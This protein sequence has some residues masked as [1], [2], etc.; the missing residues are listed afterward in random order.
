MEQQRINLTNSKGEKV[1]ATLLSNISPVEL[2]NIENEWREDKRKIINQ[3]G[4]TI[5]SR[6]ESLQSLHW[7]WSDKAGLLKLLE[8]EAYGVKTG[9]I[10]QG[11]ML[12]KTA[13]NF[14]RCEQDLGKPLIYIDYI[15]TAP[16][17]WNIK[18][19]DQVGEFRGVGPILFQEAIRRSMK[20]GYGGRIGLHSLP[21]AEDFYAK[22]GMISF[23][24]DKR[25]QNLV[26]YELSQ[27]RIKELIM[28]K[29]SKKK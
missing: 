9:D 19:L 11:A 7:N 1:E 10:W 21:Q 12:I 26:Y 4:S 27:E 5:N 22:I 28:V 3:M 17:N 13:S 23:G 16:R 18:E 2:V 25:K 6:L 24:R 20:E 14:A 29:G 15:E 8:V